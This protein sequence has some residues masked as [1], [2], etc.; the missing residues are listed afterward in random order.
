M[1]VDDAGKNKTPRGIYVMVV[2]ATGC[3]L[4]DNHVFYM[5]VVK[6]EATPKGLAFIDNRAMLNDCPHIYNV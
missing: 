3:S 2:G 4:A 6:D 5:V 1:L